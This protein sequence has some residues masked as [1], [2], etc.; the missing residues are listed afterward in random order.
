MT[1]FTLT[2]RQLER[3][4]RDGF[5]MVD[6]LIG[7]ESVTVLRERYDRLFRGDFETGISPDEVNWQEGKSDPSLTRQICNGWKADREIARVVFRADLGQAIARLAGWNGARV[8]IDNVLWKPPGTRPLG[9]HQDNAYLRW[10]EPGELLSCWIALDDTQADGGTMEVVRGSHRWAASEPEGA[11][12]GPDDYRKFMRQAAAAE[13]L[14]PDLV[15]IVVPAGGGS[16]HHGWT[17]HGSGH[18]RSATPR[19]ALVIHAMPAEARFAES[20]AD[21]SFATGPIYT[22]YKRL[23]DRTMDENYFPITWTESGYRTPGLKAYLRAA[24]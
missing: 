5:L 19:R 9:F 3:F 15:P 13:G 21:L 1:A 12:H 11:F 10:F 14:E 2:E 8:M 20:P 18:N 6:K 23:G 24:A 22:R 7:P 16:F 17:W 4:H